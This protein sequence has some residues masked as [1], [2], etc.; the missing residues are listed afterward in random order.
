MSNWPGDDAVFPLAEPIIQQF[1]GLELSPYLDS[2]GIPTIGWGTILYPNGVRVAMSD[3]AITEDYAAQC[4]TYEMTQKCAG[5]ASYLSRMPS[6]HQAAAMVSL[7]YNIGVPAFS[8]S[9]VLRQFN[10]GNFQAAAD[11]FLMWDKTHVDGQ[12]VVVDGLL[13]RRKSEQAI[14]LTPDVAAIAAVA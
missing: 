14:F 7:A 10:A 4:L 5:I 2:A 6:L 12:L 8:T 1:E 3:P 13:N 9:T 11:A